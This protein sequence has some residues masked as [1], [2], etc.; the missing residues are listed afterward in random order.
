MQLAIVLPVLKTLLCKLL[1]SGILQMFC[2]SCKGMS[3]SSISLSIGCCLY[4]PFSNSLQDFILYDLLMT[5]MLSS[6][7]TIACI[8][9]VFLTN[10]VRRAGTLAALGWLQLP[11]FR[12]GLP[13]M[14]F[15]M[16]FSACVAKLTL[17]LYDLCQALIALGTS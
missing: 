2:P 12:T 13:S 3:S 8:L 15:Q 6:I 14:T 11:H 9:Q 4:C 17:K 10:H 16:R 7:I 5:R 1:L